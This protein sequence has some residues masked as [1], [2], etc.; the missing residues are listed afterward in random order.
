MDHSQGKE[1]H[2][3]IA[4]LLK[5]VREHWEAANWK[6][7]RWGQSKGEGLGAVYD[8]RWECGDDLNTLVV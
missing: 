1:E 6:N 4:D 2:L 7:G 5:R 3:E 8:V